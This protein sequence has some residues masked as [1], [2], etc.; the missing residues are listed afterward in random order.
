MRFRTEESPISMYI[1]TGFVSF[2]AIVFVFVAYFSIRALNEHYLSQVFLKEHGEI[3]Y[4]KEYYD[5][6]GNDCLK[7][8]N[9]ECC[10][11]SV[12]AM[13]VG[14]YGLLTKEECPKYYVSNAKNC[15]GGYV[16]CQLLV[17]DDFSLNFFVGGSMFSN[18]ISIKID[19]GYITY[20]QST[21]ETNKELES[22]SRPVSAS[23]L[24]SLST[25]IGSYDLMSL[26]SQNFKVEPLIPGQAYYEVSL[27]MDKKKHNIKCGTPLSVGV[28]DLECQRGIEKLRIKLNSMLN[29]N[30]K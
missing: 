24:D 19:D 12:E 13:R 7:K 5:K 3:I 30:I 22:L 14:N 15:T 6:L 17:D 16:W 2:A 1:L 20:K 29:I 21:F 8:E 4:S 26:K 28:P 11:S 10:L 18:N 25:I 9:K 27:F 23:E